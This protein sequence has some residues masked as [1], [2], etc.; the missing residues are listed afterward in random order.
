[1]A[2]RSGAGVGGRSCRSPRTAG[3]S[4]RA[5]GGCRGDA[6]GGDGAGVVCGWLR[7]SPRSGGPGRSDAGPCGRS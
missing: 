7:R 5:E 3:G 4:D 2:G 1:V 6:G